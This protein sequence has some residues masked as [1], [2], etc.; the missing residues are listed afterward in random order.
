M[1]GLGGFIILLYLIYF[2]ARASILV[3]GNQERPRARGGMLGTLVLTRSVLFPLEPGFPWCFPSLRSRKLLHPADQAAAEVDK[4]PADVTAEAVEHAFELGAAWWEYANS[5]AHFGLTLLNMMYIYLLTV[6]L[7]SLD[8]ITD[9]NGTSRLRSDTK[10]VCTNKAHTRVQAGATF[11][12]LVLGVVVPASYAAIVHRMRRVAK[13]RT[14]PDI[15]KRA[16]ARWWSGLND[17]LTRVSGGVL[18]EMYMHAP[19]QAARSGSSGS[20]SLRRLT[21]RLW[22]YTWKAAEE[23]VDQHEQDSAAAAAHMMPESNA[24]PVRA[25]LTRWQ[26]VRIALASLRFVVRV[27][28]SRYY[29]SVLFIQRF[30]IVLAAYVLRDSAPQQA[31]FQICMYACFGLFG[32][33]VKP[34]RCLDLRAPL[35]WWLSP[36]L[37]WLPEELAASLADG[38]QDDLGWHII[39]S[40][41]ECYGWFPGWYR[42]DH[43]V[44][45]DVLN[46]THLSSNVVLMLTVAS[47]LAANGRGTILLTILL[48]GI[49]MLQFIYNG[50]TLTLKFW[51]SWSEDF[52]GAKKAAQSGE[53][54]G[55]IVRVWRM[56]FPTPLTYEEL[57]EYLQDLNPADKQDSMSPIQFEAFRVALERQV[58]CCLARMQARRVLLMHDDALI[59]VNEALL[60]DLENKMLAMIELFVD[61]KQLQAPRDE[62]VDLQSFLNKLQES[63]LDDSGGTNDGGADPSYAALRASNN[64]RRRRATRVWLKRGFALTLI[65]CMVALIASAFSIGR[66]TLASLQISGVKAPPA[67]SPPPPSPFPPPLPPWPSPPPPPPSEVSL[68]IQGIDASTFNVSTVSA[69][70]AAAVPGAVPLS[71]ALLVDLHAT[72]VLLF[73]RAGGVGT[74]VRLSRDSAAQVAGMLAT[75]LQLERS[76]VFSS[77]FVV[78]A[79]AAGR[80]RELLAAALTTD[81]EVF[82]SFTRLGTVMADVAALDSALRSSSTLSALLSVLTYTGFGSVTVTAFRIDADVLLISAGYTGAQ[83]LYAALSS[84]ALSA[85]LTAAGMVFTALTAQRTAPP[86]PPS[87]PFPPESPPPSPPPPLSPPK[88]PPPPRPPRP[89]KPPPPIPPSPPNPPPPPPPP[90]S[91]PPPPVPPPPSPPPSPPLPPSPSPPPI[92]LS[93][94]SCNCYTNSQC[95]SYSC[96]PYSCNGYTCPNQCGSPTWDG[97][98]S[99]CSNSGCGFLWL[100][101]CYGGCQTCYS[102]CYQ[103]CYTS[104]VQCSSCACE[105]CPVG[106]YRR[107]C[108]GSSAGSCELCTGLPAGTRW[109]TDGGAADACTY[110]VPAG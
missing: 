32:A 63:F 12:V 77:Q 14:P 69:A 106:Q 44:L 91:P 62:E 99:K 47:V 26:R 81:R 55:F 74:Q 11:L 7:R 86:P 72:A 17:P 16:D 40:E 25:R 56:I 29:E 85:E 110:S 57:M 108:G 88:P 2:L 97:C 101:S 95:S 42:C 102:T 1:L 54:P 105:R 28:L 49:N 30:L 35:P 34:F 33:W 45:L 92:Q 18:Y 19:L 36:P 22:A 87:P 24:A 64:S 20:T 23:I 68:Q 27:R 15:A 84:G 94:Y 98:G 52:Q 46:Y 67:P 78:P 43:V 80:R 90:P 8:C 76:Q 96:N 89:P 37:P 3:Q 31:A 6:S 70:A 79:G 51:L 104:C 48:V 59:Q 103:T 58:V 60:K 82:V 13:R 66:R 71:G 39:D 5:M 100:L 83:P 4:L 10:T 65:T 109:I 93:S 38:T 9:A 107:G 53:E 75:T 41:T 61:E 50:A 21:G 73:S